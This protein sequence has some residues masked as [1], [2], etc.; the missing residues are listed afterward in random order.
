MVKRLIGFIS[1]LCLTMSVVSQTPTQGQ[2]LSAFVDKND[3]ALNDI[4]TLTIRVDNSLGTTRPSLA[5]LNRDFEQVGNVNTRSSYTNVNGT[6][7]S[8][9]DFIIRLRAL[10]SGTLIIPSFR[11]GGEVTSPISINVGEANQTDSAGNNE[12]FILSNVSKERLYVQE[13]L[14]YT[15]KLY[16]SISFDQGAQL[17]SPQVADSVVQQLGSDETYSEILD[18]IRYNVTERKFVIFPQS[19]GELTI[20]PVYFTATVGRRGGLTRFFNNR[21]SVREIDLSSDAHLI[22]VLGKPA[23]FPGQTWL[24]AANLSII[25]NWSGPLTNLAIGNSVTRNIRLTA[26]GLS[27]SLL[28]G[29][30]YEDI[31]GLKFYPD[32]PIRE[33][34]A[35]ETGVSGS[36]AE[37]TAIVPSEAGSFIIP[38]VVIPWWN[39]TTDSLERT[40]I[41][42]QTMTVLPGAGPGQQ[43]L[44][45]FSNLQQAN[46][47]P[48]PGSAAAPAAQTSGL[49]LFWITSTAVFAVAW[50]FST[51][52]W[53]RYRNQLAFVTTATPGMLPRKK[54]I[55]KIVSQ[56]AQTNFKSLKTALARGEP[57]EIRCCL[58]A[59]GQALFQ[60]NS[61][62]TLTAISRQCQ[63]GEFEKQTLLLEE[64]V[65]KNSDTKD[66]STE[67]IETAVSRIHKSASKPKSAG[68]NYNLPPLYKN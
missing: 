23:S 35:D 60:D 56:N 36:R 19:S 11:V 64:S 45:D 62:L 61:L 49:Y 12:I 46:F 7:Q 4:L 10:S 2:A 1:L 22:D 55:E 65:Y 59:W 17:T 24:P 13:Q 20:P 68:K 54:D 8:F 47:P 33:D 14:L 44:P 42:A 43:A 41:P 50:L 53:L 16:Y 37:G 51:G 48:G 3:I 57:T 15:I 5:G 29:I 58:I 40:V 52:M 6:V 31:P 25:E 28:P 27:S 32:Q 34:N 18:G 66:F 67:I 63:D 38:E 30:S 9:V 26:T 39:T 21:T